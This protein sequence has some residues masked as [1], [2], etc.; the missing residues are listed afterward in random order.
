MF[1]EITGRINEHGQLEVELPANLPPGEVRIII[2][3]IDAEAEEADEAQWN[4]Q[5]AKSQDALARLADEIL[6]DDLAG[7]TEDFEPDDL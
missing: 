5:F 7:L 3:R 4:E 2:E 6:A 1:I